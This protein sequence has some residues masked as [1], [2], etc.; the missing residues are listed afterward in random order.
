MDA[1]AEAATEAAANLAVPD[2][3]NHRS[4]AAQQAATDATAAAMRAATESLPDDGPAP[5]DVTEPDA[6]PK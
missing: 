5:P 6:D 2:P 4:R 1:A 3:R